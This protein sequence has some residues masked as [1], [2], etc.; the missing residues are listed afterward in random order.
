VHVLRHTLN[1]ILRQAA[2]ELVRQAIVG[3]ADAATGKRYSNVGADEKRV[4]LAAVV[5]MVKPGVKPGPGS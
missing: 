5:G 4:A 3:H 2:P 1:N